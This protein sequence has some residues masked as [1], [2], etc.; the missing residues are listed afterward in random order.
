MKLRTG[1]QAIIIKLVVDF[2]RT[3]ANCNHT[4]AR[5]AA[6]RLLALADEVIE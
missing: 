6:L 3:V 4:G 2:E 5:L 1:W